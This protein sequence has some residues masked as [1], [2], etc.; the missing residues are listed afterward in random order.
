[1]ELKQNAD[2]SKN[3]IN[4]V[5]YGSLILC[6]LLATVISFVLYKHTEDLLKDR[7]KE[8]LIAIV[9]TAALNFDVEVLDDIQGEESLGTEEYTQTVEKLLLLRNYNE[10]LKF[11]Y[12]LRPT[13]D[14]YVYT[15]IA[16]ADSLDPNVEIDL[17]NDGVIDDED[18]LA[19]P[20]DEYDVTDVPALVDLARHKPVTDEEP[21]V[22]QWGTFLSAYAPIKSKG[23]TIAVLGIDVEVSQYLELVRKTFVPFVLFISFLLLILIILTQT[24][25]RIWKLQV[26]AVQ[27]VDKQKDEL[28]SI[29][30]HQLATPVSSI[31]WYTE[32]MSDGD[33]GKITKQQKEHLQ[34]MMGVA[35]NL[36]DLVS[37]IL[38]VSRI[39]LGRMHIE[40]QELDLNIFFKEI[41]EIINPKAEQ[42]KIKFA[43]AMPKKL[44]KAM[45]DRR[46]THMT[47]ENLLSNAVKYTPE[48]GSVDFKLDVKDNTMYCEIRDTGVGIPKTD[49]QK[50]FG[51]MF[52]ATN[53]RNE[54]DGNGFGLYV[55]KGAVEAQ[56]GKIWFQSQE[57]KGTTFFV[58]LPLN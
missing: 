55:A 41:L 58:E 3:R 1:M 12:L 13:E 49:Q 4:F 9:S 54:V 27:E 33:L 25:V 43:V 32:M 18:A 48:G 28:L 57:G 30:S 8:R 24:L 53:V 11:A 34:S 44:P 45:L 31:K 56:G 46:Y 10:N 22:D 38:D 17:N 16:D 2:G 37:M 5:S 6:C 51:K 36:A 40:K 26:Q 21:V 39:Q 52:R 42:K 35:G 14:Q 47:I 23:E 15:F 29:V 20:G 50:I 7:L 19:F